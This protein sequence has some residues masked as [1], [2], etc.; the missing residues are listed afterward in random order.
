VFRRILVAYDD[1]SAARQALAEALQLAQQQNAR[2]IVLAVEEHLP[3]YDGATLGEVRDEHERKQRDCRRWARTA[4]A[5]AAVCGVPIRTEIR[6]GSLARQLASA[7]TAHRADL[8]VVG[9][10]HHPGIWARLA[11]TKAGKVSRR[12]ACP[13][14]IASAPRSPGT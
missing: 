10:T 8:V 12:V 3:R 7:A 2:L 11:G 14:L 5:H 1:S 9:R 6:T 4:E 13:V